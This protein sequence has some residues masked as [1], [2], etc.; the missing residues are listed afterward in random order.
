MTPTTR[1]PV[2][3]AVWTLGFVSLLMDMSSEMVHALLPVL[4]SSVLGASALSIGLL[5]GASEALVLVTKTFS[6][7]ISD[8]FGKRKPLVLLGYGLAALTKPLF[9]M[10]DSIGMVV[11]ARR[12]TVSVKAFAAHPAMR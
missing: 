8:A 1:T 4:L 3:R 7:Y 12:W 9:P 5:E 10:A 2:P 11:T 6:G